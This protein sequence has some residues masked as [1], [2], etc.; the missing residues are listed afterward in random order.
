MNLAV[1]TL[2]DVTVLVSAA[3]AAVALLRER[4]AALRHAILACAV[5]GALM[6]PLFERMLPQLPVLP[7]APPA[8]AVSDVRSAPV[9]QA[10]PSTVQVV[11]SGP[12]VL[13]WSE[14]LLALWAAGALVMLAMLLCRLVRLRQLTRR[15]TPAPPGKLQD[16]VHAVAR[17]CGLRPSVRLLLSEG[18][19][20]IFTCGLWHPTIV[21]P[22][23]AVEW[24]DDR[25]HL[26][27]AHECAHIRRRDVLMH[28]AGEL[29]RAIHWF[30]PLVARVCRRLRAESECACDDA[31][32]RAGVRA[33]DYAAH[34]LALARQ[35]SR[36]GEWTVAPAIV[37]PSTLERRIAMILGSHTREPLTRRGR[38][39]ALLAVTS[40]ALPLAAADVHRP[41]ALPLDEPPVAARSL[42]PFAASAD[43][44]KVEGGVAE[45][46]RRAHVAALAPIDSTDGATQRV[47]PRQPPAP[48][49]TYDASQ[50]PRD[51]VVLT[52]NGLSL[53]LQTSTDDPTGSILGVVLDQT[54]GVMP[55]ATLV[56]N[57]GGARPRTT[58]SDQNGRFLLRNLPPGSYELAAGANGFATL[59]QALTVG[60][61]ESATSAF[62]LPVGTLEERLTVTCNVVA[63]W[64]SPFGVMREVLGR[65]SGAFMPVLSAQGSAR[66]LPVRVGGNLHAPRKITDVK[67]ACPGEPVAPS[68]VAIRLIG[69]IDVN[70]RVKEMR[71]LGADGA[72]QSDS[73]NQSALEAA[74]QWTFTPATLNGVAVEVTVAV[75][76][77]YRPA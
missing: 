2:L 51:I 10:S 4:S 29:L 36:H 53:N 25:L 60:P 1:A 20:S 42:A 44:P 68:G 32:L 7:G 71:V 65:A 21:L 59:V 55:G 3:L 6:V 74:R 45:A 24:A 27:L 56:L 13:T 16:A 76:V 75:H 70:G 66:P 62:T 38:L 9:P 14:A 8:V 19:A 39:L 28:L 26:V 31:V 63:A 5:I 58:L 46:R 23:T 30:N 67:P 12:P 47:E 50:I 77:N 37:H 52:D 69:R 22:Q 35:A 15:C 40:V 72:Q 34:L 17:Q 43:V 11:V 18:T 48:Q 61:G 73:F 64:A 54:G 41:G 33:A 49:L 57:D